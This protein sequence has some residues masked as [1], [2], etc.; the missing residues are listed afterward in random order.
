MQSKLNPKCAI[1]LDSSDPIA[2]AVYH[3]LSE[4]IERTS[5]LIYFAFITISV[6]AV[7]VPTTIVSYVN[8]YV[9]GLN[10]EESFHLPAPIL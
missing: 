2:N 9:T 10:A 8:F 1:N 6:P 4:K 5:K 3:K 7:T